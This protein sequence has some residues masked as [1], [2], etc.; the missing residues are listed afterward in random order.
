MN[1]YKQN[2]MTKIEEVY[3]LISEK[4]Y[5]DEDG[6]D[7]LAIGDVHEIIAILTIWKNAYH[8]K[9]KERCLLEF[10][11]GLIKIGFFKESMNCY[12][13]EREDNSEPQTI[14]ANRDKNPIVRWRSFN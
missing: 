8:L 10:E 14:S 5:S 6:K 13:L 7:I 12:F 4:V 11:N 3:K 9:P 1:N 2:K